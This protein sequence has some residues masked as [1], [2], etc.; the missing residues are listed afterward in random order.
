MLNLS[1]LLPLIGC[2]D[3]NAE[4]KWDTELICEYVW[5][6]MALS[7]IPSLLLYRDVPLLAELI[8][9]RKFMLC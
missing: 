9:G 8:G 3:G 6:F 2:G 7:A 5:H 1:S 4:G